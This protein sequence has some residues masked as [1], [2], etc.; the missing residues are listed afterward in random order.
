M[1]WKNLGSD[2]NSSL[3]LK[4]SSDLELL[5][6]QFSNVIPENSNESENISSSKFYDIDEM[7]NVKIPHRNKSLSLF[8]INACFF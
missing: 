6:N 7:H 2:H 4:P 5:V 1:Q 8:Y 3:L